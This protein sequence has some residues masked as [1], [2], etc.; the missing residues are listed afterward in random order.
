MGKGD[1]IGMTLREKVA[2][3]TRKSDGE[4]SFSE[5]E[6]GKGLRK[7]GWQRMKG[8]VLILM[9]FSCSGDV[10]W[11]YSLFPVESRIVCTICVMVPGWRHRTVERIAC[12][13]ANA[14]C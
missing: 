13:T 8:E 2:M 9:D 14:R 6:R 5:G 4:C 12:F 10:A 3:R 7:Q 11:R 1:V